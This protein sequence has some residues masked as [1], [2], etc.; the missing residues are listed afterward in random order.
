MIDGPTYRLSENL[1]RLQMPS[2]HLAQ[3]HQVPFDIDTF[4]KNPMSI[5]ELVPIFGSMQEYRFDAYM[6]E[7]RGLSERDVDAVVGALVDC[8]L[9]Q[10]TAFP[11]LRPSLPFS[12]VMACFSLFRKIVGW[13]PEAST[14]LEIG[15]G[16]G[17]L[18]LFLRHHA[19][20]TQYAQIEAC[21]G[22]YLLQSVINDHA[23]PYEVDDRALPQGQ[24]AAIDYYTSNNS[25]VEPPTYAEWPA[26]QPRC[27]H[28]PW[29]RLGEIRR[30]GKQFDIVTSNANLREF[31]SQALQDYLC[32]IKD[33][34]KP[35]GVLLSQ[36]LGGDVYRN[37]HI[38]RAELTRHDYAAVVYI[39]QGGDVHVSGPEGRPVTKHFGTGQAVLVSPDHPLH[40]KYQQPGLAEELI[41][42]NEPGV[43]RMFF[44]DDEPR[45]MYAIPELRLMVSERLRAMLGSRALAVSAGGAA[46]LAPVPHPVV[47]PVS[48]KTLLYAGP[49]LSPVEKE[50]NR[51]E[52]IAAPLVNKLVAEW[53]AGNKRIAVYGAGAHTQV[54]ATITRLGEANVVGVLDSNPATWGREVLGHRVGGPENVDTL[55]PDVILISS[56]FEGEI[57]Q[58]LRPRLDLTIEVVRLHS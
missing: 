43:I 57:Y 2:W 33:V 25:M 44:P 3:I 6:E 29:W 30:G 8:V 56:M 21:Q 1:A 13:A 19:P 46:P 24:D 34:L 23:F 12:V 7:W 5:R 48:A 18:P 10:R 50:A 16:A 35:G 15:P 14:I 47:T 20:L 26:V 42:G 45:R 54:L 40:Q 37:D 55:R 36:C 58:Q 53:I 49:V 32:L 31:S 52:S 41:L 17:L 11:G 4:A 28:Y 39:P 22:Y 27:V 9:L 38:L 51:L